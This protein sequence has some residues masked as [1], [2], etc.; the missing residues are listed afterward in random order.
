MRGEFYS[1]DTNIMV[2]VNFMPNEVTT[3]LQ[4]R[5]GRSVFR[6][7]R[8]DI[9]RY[10]AIY[11]ALPQSALEVVDATGHVWSRADIRENRGAV[12]LDFQGPPKNERTPAPESDQR[13]E[14]EDDDEVQQVGGERGTDGEA[15]QRAVHVQVPL[16][17]QVDARLERTEKRGSEGSPDGLHSNDDESD[18]LDD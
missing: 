8:I 4:C 18:V 13:S 17:G 11:N 15:V 2:T 5:R 10:Q 3:Y 1:K 7:V 6:K 14:T 16:V 12:T 9:G